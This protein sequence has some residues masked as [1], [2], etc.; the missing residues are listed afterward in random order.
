MILLFKL[1]L[2]LSVNLSSFVS[3]LLYKVLSVFYQK[4]FFFLHFLNLYLHTFTFLYI[5]CG[6]TFAFYDI[7]I[8]SLF[9][10]KISFQP[11]F[12]S[13]KV[14]FYCLPGFSAPFLRVCVVT[15]ALKKFIS[16]RNLYLI[17]KEHPGK[18]LPL[19]SSFTGIRNLVKTW[20]KWSS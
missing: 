13:P 16:L 14:H 3:L 11:K 6:L 8:C 2:Q 20:K 19:N 18:F 4:L 9:S 15:V 12:S 5:K 10:T 17:D 7:P 1:A